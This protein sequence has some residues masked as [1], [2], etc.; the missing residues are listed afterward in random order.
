MKTKKYENLIILR[1]NYENPVV[2]RIP[3][4]NHENH[5]N[6]LNPRQNYENQFLKKS[7]TEFQKL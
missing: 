3:S 4:K 1:Q 5:E 6:V 2:F 7:T